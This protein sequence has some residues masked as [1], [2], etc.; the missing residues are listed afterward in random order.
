MDLPLLVS[1]PWV[2]DEEETSDS[3]DGRRS[4]WGHRDGPAPKDQE[5]IEV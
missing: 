4:F 1:V 5:R 2:A 3:G